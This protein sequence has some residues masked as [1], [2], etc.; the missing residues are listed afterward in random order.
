MFTQ[1]T[2]V[3][4]TDYKLVQSCTSFRLKYGFVTNVLTRKVWLY[5]C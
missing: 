5:L 4:A 3:A 1:D 2:Y